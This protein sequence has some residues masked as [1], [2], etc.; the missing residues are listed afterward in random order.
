ML[1]LFITFT[2]A[3]AIDNVVQQWLAVEKSTRQI[4]VETAVISVGGG[5]VGWCLAGLAVYRTKDIF[6]VISYVN[7]I[8]GFLMFGASVFIVV[9]LKCRRRNVGVLETKRRPTQEEDFQKLCILVALVFCFCSAAKLVATALM[10]S[11]KGKGILPSSTL[12]FWDC[13]ATIFNSWT[14]LFIYIIASPNFR[15]ALFS[16]FK[17]NVTTLTTTMSVS[18]YKSTNRSNLITTIA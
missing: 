16:L 10:A 14:N 9:R 1:T 5:F 17:I 2:R 6:L 15:Q 18:F 8:V 7:A 13:L 3:K 11:V 4:Y 12:F